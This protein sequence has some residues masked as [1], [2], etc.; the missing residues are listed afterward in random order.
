MR[1]VFIRTLAGLTHTAFS[2]AKSRRR[3][4]ARKM[5]VDWTHV[6]V[7]GRDLTPGHFVVEPYVCDV[8]VEG[9]TAINDSLRGP[10]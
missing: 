2:R 1:S 4:G 3:A 8:S 7:A 6:S 9:A 10:A 5:R